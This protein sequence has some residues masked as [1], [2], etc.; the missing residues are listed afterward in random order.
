MRGR[1]AARRR[2]IRVL[3]G[4]GGGAGAYV[5]CPAASVEATS[6]PPSTSLVRGHDTVPFGTP[7]AAAIAAAAAPGAFSTCATMRDSTSA[8]S[9]ALRFGA[10]RRVRTRTGMTSGA[11]ANAPFVGALVAGF[12][13]AG[14][15]SSFGGAA[16][17]STRL[18]AS[19]LL[20]LAGARLVGALLAG[21]RLVRALSVIEAGAD[22]ARRF[23]VAA[24]FRGGGD[25]AAIAPS[26]SMSAR[27]SAS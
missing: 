3:A 16:L 2:M 22:V 19:G 24:R 21:A 18:L 20:V 14:R 17:V 25:G 6:F 10:R 23:A 9:S 27:L 7:I 15:G 1:S 13:S 26:P 12:D 8:I 5:F 11:R 4:S